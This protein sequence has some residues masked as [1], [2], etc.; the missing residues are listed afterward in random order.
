[1]IRF[2]LPEIFSYFGHDQ[3]S[4]HVFKVTRDAEIDIETTYLLHLFRKLKKG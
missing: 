2:N 1:V 4:A 3:Y